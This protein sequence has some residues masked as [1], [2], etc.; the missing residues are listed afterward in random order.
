MDSCQ[1]D[2][3]EVAEVQRAGGHDGRIQ[4]RASTAAAPPARQE[5]LRGAVR[6]PEVS[7]ARRL[8]FHRIAEQSR[9]KKNL[10]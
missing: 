10:S 6:G 8:S 5:Y 3:D 9:L 7:A 1:H 2:D 4:S